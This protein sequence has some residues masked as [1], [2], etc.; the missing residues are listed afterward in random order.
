L[1][2]PD[3]LGVDQPQLLHEAERA[4][5]Q[6]NEAWAI[7]QRNHGSRDEPAPAKAHTA[8]AQSA[9]PPPTRRPRP[10]ECAI[11][12]CSP[13]TRTRLSQV[14]G[15]LVG[16]RRSPIDMTLCRSC[17][18]SLFR[19]VQART[20]ARGW[21]GV[22]AVIAT[23]YYAIRNLCARAA[24]LRL[25]PPHQGP[26]DVVR[27][28]GT[29]LP[30]TVP[31]ARRPLVLLASSVVVAVIVSGIVVAGRSATGPGCG[32]PRAV[33]QADLSRA[34]QY[35]TVAATEQHWAQ[36]AS[37]EILSNQRCFPRSEIDDAQDFEVGGF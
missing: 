16:W 28:R 33:V 25:P 24:L 26:P 18:L 37:T 2:H 22:L 15:M 21:W 6:L 31:V 12:A 30:M 32:L 27:P 19:D 1:L 35:E 20:L 29:P 11:C 4:M 5:A 17:G 7:V 34:Q 10:D 9:P 8:P 36:A 23:T 14:T 3:R 13:A